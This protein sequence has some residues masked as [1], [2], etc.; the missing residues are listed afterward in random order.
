MKS[1]ATDKVLKKR[2]LAERT[3]KPKGAP[4]AA[5]AAAPPPAAAPA[6]SSSGRAWTVSLALPGSIVDNAQTQELRSHLVGQ[7]ARAATIFN[8]DEIVV[9]SSDGASPAA[10]QR[11]DGSVFMARLLQYLECPQ[12]LRKA[13]F[14]M[15]PDLRCVGLL[16]PL[17]AANHPRATEQPHLGEGRL[18]GRPLGVDRRLP[19]GTRVTVRMPSRPGEPAAVVPPREPREKLGLHW[20]FSVRLAKDLPSVWS[21]C[22]FGGGYDLSLGT[23]D[24]GDSD[25]LQGEGFRLPAFKHLLIVFGG[26]SSPSPSA[27]REQALFDLYLNLCPGQGSRTIRTEEAL[28]VG[29]AA[30]QPHTRRAGAS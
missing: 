18:Q 10:P 30:L 25:W 27:S 28:L 7:V 2:R 8:V 26:A 6:A 22:P 15:H 29:L 21:E 23:S 16:A 19:A 5:S 20:G 4:A 3:P 13:I 11:T 14:P 17:D 24:K 1:S 9:F 12:Y